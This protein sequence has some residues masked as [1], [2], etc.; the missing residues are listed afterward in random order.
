VFANLSG[1]IECRGN[2]IA[3]GFIPL[4]VAAGVTADGKAKYSG[5]IP[6]DTSSHRG[7]STGARTAAL[8][9]RQRSCRND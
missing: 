3:R 5:L 8:S 4:L 1:N 2:I 6:C 9:C 7:A